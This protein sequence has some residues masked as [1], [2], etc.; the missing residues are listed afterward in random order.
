MRRSRPRATVWQRFRAGAQ[1]AAIDILEHDE[2]FA[3]GG[4]AQ[5]V[6]LHDVLVRQR[7]VDARL[8]LQH[9][10]EARVVGQARQHT[11]D[12]DHLFEA[13]FAART[14]EKQLGHGAHGE[15]LEQ[16]VVAQGACVAADATQ[17]V[18]MAGVA[19]HR[20]LLVAP[21]NCWAVLRLRHGR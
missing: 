7:R 14:P 20:L 2:V 1:I 21:S 13:F 9:L 18:P 15:A 17:D 19:A 11:L 8:G 12:D 3:V 5:V 4:N 16:L 10:H 6:N